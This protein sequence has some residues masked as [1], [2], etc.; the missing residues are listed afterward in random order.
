VLWHP[1]LAVAHVWAWIDNPAGPFA[2]DNAALVPWGGTPDGHRHDRTAAEAA[3]STLNHHVA[4]AILMVIA[5]ATW[6][7]TRIAR[8]FPWCAVSAP[9]WMAFSVYLF[10]SVDPEAWPLGPG[11]IADGLADA[12]VVQ[13]KLLAVIPMVI[14]L[15]EMLRR[16]GWLRSRRWYVVVPSLG[17]LGGAT[18]F[19]H[20]HHGG[21]H[22]GQM[23]IHHGLM[24]LSA[25]TG[26]VALV[27]AQRS[28]TGRALLVRA[29]PIFLVLMALL[30]LV[31]SEI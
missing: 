12:L 14:G 21:G 20:G 6:W 2:L 23:F 4:G 10:L 18:L 25:V 11:T 19:V 28:E 8:R 13:H 30:L 5:L 3:Y 15:V 29:W 24:G 31:Y 7:E 26:S 17:L 22:L 16:A 1:A 27:L 9:L